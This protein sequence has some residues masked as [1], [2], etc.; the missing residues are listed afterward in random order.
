MEVAL[1]I[2]RAWRLVKFIDAKMLR[3][4]PC[5]CCH[6]EFVVREFDLTRHYV[7]GLCAIPSRAGKKRPLAEPLPVEA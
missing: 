7:C 2:T 1:S 4:A 3:L 5:T 6:G